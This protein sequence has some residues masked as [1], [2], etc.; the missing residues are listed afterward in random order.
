MEPNVERGRADEDGDHHWLRRQGQEGRDGE[1]ARQREANGEEAPA[2]VGDAPEER[3]DDDLE[4]A[5]REEHGCDLKRRPARI[6]QRQRRQ[7]D[8]HPEEEGGQR[9]QPQ[10]AHEAAIA[11]RSREPVRRERLAGGRASKQREHSEH[12]LQRRRAPRT[13]S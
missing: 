9:V 12:Q 4:K 3:V 5:C 11:E 7:D 13:R 8:E 2:A 6:V 10:A 1:R